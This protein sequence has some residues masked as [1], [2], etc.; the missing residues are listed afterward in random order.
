M[1]IL[2]NEAKNK[3]GEQIELNGWIYTRRDHGKLIFFDMRDRSGIV[4]LVV[5]P[6]NKELH[7]LADSLRPEWVVAVSG[8]V[9]NRP[10]NMKNTTIPTGGIEIKIDKIEILS[11]SETPPIDIAGDGR[12]IDEEI[13]IRNRYFDL[14]RE[15][16]QKN[17]RLR[18]KFTKSIR[19]FL[20]KKEFIEIETPMLTKSTPEGARDFVVPSRMH[21]GKFYAL[22]QSPQQYKQL[23]MTAGFERYFQ[24]A[25]A[26]RD[27]DTR[28]DR[29]LEHTQIDLEMS[30]VEQNDVLSI[31]EELIINSIESIGGTIM[32]KPFPRISYKEAIDKYGADKFDLREDKESNELAFA[33]VTDFP[34]FEKDK[35]GKLTYSH[36]PFT[37]PKP[38]D[39]ELM[40]NG[41]NPE[42]LVAQQYDLVCNG[43]E[44]GSGGIRVNN[45]DVLSK[46]FE[47]IGHNKEEIEEKFGHMLRAFRAGTPP[48][49][50]IALGLDRLMM[51]LTNETAM[52]EV[53][54]FPLTGDGRDPLMDSPSELSKEQLKELG[55]KTNT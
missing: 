28:A 45:P 29:G 23:L 19:D 20:H 37:S 14:R 30:F 2:T 46:V 26:M 47:I 9:K 36:N 11:T 1:R 12:E 52:R 6:D 55:I 34:M 41:E 4:Q 10:E 17:L 21:P 38:K 7:S 25:R 33:W 13:R 42:S 40:M 22:P 8:E 24:I 32:T 50:G 27:E 48:H 43:Y 54:A 18:S 3:I 15:R 51:I 39:T 35:N 53:V 49:G 31:V 16:L 44:I 5:T